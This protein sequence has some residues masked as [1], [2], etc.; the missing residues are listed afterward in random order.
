MAEEGGVGNGNTRNLLLLMISRATRSFAA[1]FIAVV[2]GLYYTNDLGLSLTLVGII[3]GAGALATPI[4]TLFTGR[5]ADLYGRKLLLLLSLL[6]LPGSLAILLLSTYFPLLLVSAAMGGFGIAGGLVGGGVGAIAAPMQTALLAEKTSSGNRTRVFSVFTIIST[7]SGSTGALLSNVHS[8]H[9]LFY[10][11]LIISLVSAIAI[12]PLHEDFKRPEHSAG[13]KR[14]KT[15]KTSKNRKIISMFSATGTL[16][17]TSQGLIIPFLPI[18]LRLTF[19]MSNG[20]IGDLFSVGG[21][22]TAAAT[23]LTPYATKKIGFVRLIMATRTFSTVFLVIFPFA[24]EVLAASFFYIVFTA[25]RAMS[26]P[27]QQALMMTLVDEEYRASATGV[28]QTARLLPAAGA[29]AASGSVQDYFGILIP[30]E[31]ASAISFFNVFVYYRFFWKMPAAGSTQK[32]S[33]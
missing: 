25:L 1:G 19:N 18:I 24:P 7:L 29:T 9:T 4:L 23:T 8:Y 32:T 14:E 10:L 3:F 6:L 12:L 5:M 31:L 30:F 27:S 11:A 28:N 20:Q 26:L 2:I 13:A 16:N 15:A 22:L 21:F 33:N 17:G